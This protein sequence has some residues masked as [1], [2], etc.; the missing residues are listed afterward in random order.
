MS[1]NIFSSYSAKC[2]S[3]V[4][5]PFKNVAEDASYIER[6]PNACI[7]FAAIRKTT[8]KRA[9]RFRLS[10]SDGRAIQ[11]EPA[12][13]KIVCGRD[14]AFLFLHSRPDLVHI[15]TPLRDLGL[16]ATKIKENIWKKSACYRIVDGFYCHQTA[17]LLIKPNFAW[18]SF[19]WMVTS[20]RSKL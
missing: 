12:A 7:P 8:K 3:P 2:I 4:L 1:K 19:S 13:G 11:Q 15:K 20:I 5:L 18:F 16:A 9:L 17:M 14:S 10:L 6:E